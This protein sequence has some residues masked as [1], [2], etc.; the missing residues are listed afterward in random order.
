MK[1]LTVYDDALNRG[2]PKWPAITV[3]GDDVSQVQAAEILIRTDGHMPDFEYA[4][5]SRSLNERLSEIFGLPIHRLDHS[6]TSVEE[7]FD[8]MVPHWNAVS[9]LRK[10]LKI[11]ELEYL[12]NYQIA[13]SYIGGPH[14][15]VDWYGRVMYSGH[16][17]GK[18]PSIETVAKE[19][20]TIAKAF[21]FLNLRCQL[22]DRESCEVGAEPVVTFEVEN[23]KVA[24][25]KP[26]KEIIE[27][28]EPDFETMAFQCATMSSMTRESGIPVHL[29][30]DKVLEVYGRIPKYMLSKKDIEDRKALRKKQR[31][32]AAK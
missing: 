7:R 1:G 18:W 24:A 9:R 25:R 8:I 4:T 21:P 29:L 26:G 30:R 16:N 3:I 10:R 31:E 27:V 20:V 5:N 14:G 28:D 6:S 22:Y 12:S 19:W 13:S 2:L 32:E 11:L 23:G 15:W 17:I